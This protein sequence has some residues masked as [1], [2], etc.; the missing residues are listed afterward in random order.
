MHDITFLEPVQDKLPMSGPFSWLI[1]CLPPPCHKSHL[2]PP[3]H[4]PYLLCFK[5]TI[6]EA[7]GKR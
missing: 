5:E 3:R 7:V 1:A 2:H 6:D 4:Q